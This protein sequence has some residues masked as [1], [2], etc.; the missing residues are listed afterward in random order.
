VTYDTPLQGNFLPRL[1]G[2]PKTKLC[3]KFEVPS[4]SSFEDMFDCM[5][6]IVGSRDLSQAPIGKIYL[7]ARSAFP[8]RSYVVCTKFEVP[9]SSSSEDMI[10]R[11]PK[12]LGVT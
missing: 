1:L 8:R 9:S 7:C 4:S 5:P 10:G 6:K 11:M 3:R 12:I 2:F